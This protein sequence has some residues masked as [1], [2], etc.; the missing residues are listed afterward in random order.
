MTLRINRT[1][2]VHDPRERNEALPMW[3]HPSGTERPMTQYITI[4]SGLPRSGTSMM[5]QMLKAGGMEVIVDNVRKA[6]DDNPYGYYEYEKVKKIKEDSSFLDQAYGKAFKMVSML[7]YEL[8]HDKQ[9]KVIFMRRN[10]TEMILSQKVMLQ[11]SNNSVEEYNGEEMRKVI[12][13][14]LKQVISWLEEQENMDVIYVNYHEAIEHPLS[15]AHTINQFLSNRL[16]VRK[17]VAA[18]DQA[19]YRNRA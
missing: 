8:P 15:S 18:I 10:T 1:V 2:A 19:L 17:M 7:L 16:D 11:G 5:M 3:K 4:V 6:D 14:H 12:E 13:K 9:Y